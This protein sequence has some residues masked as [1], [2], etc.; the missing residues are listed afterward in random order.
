ML[1]IFILILSRSLLCHIVKKDRLVLKG[2]WKIWL[3]EPKKEDEMVPT[4][5]E[6]KT[7]GLLEVWNSPS[8]ESYFPQFVPNL[9]NISTL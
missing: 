9:A 6:Q 5:H 8:S 4:F 7:F 2:I 3:D 1:E